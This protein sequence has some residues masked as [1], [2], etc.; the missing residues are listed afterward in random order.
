M[1]AVLY[2]ALS[3]IS[4]INVIVHSIGLYL[5]LC[6]QKN[7]DE[8]VQQI[9]IINLSVVE[10]FGNILWFISD[11]NKFIVFDSI[12]PYPYITQVNDYVSFITCT[13]F[14]FVYYMSMVLITI[15]K[16]LEIFL[17]IKY[18]LYCSA[19]RAKYLVYL[20]WMLGCF[21]C[22]GII[23]ACKIYGLQYQLPFI[24]FVYPA[25]DIFLILIVVI[26]YSYIFH[27]YKATRSHPFQRQDSTLSVF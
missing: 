8:N 22:I 25:F 3:T 20:T 2:G 12:T 21:F 24:K 27:R 18:T 7:Y 11:L 23:L 10:I 17:N 19:L 26:C 1:S 16:S 6:I 5:L 4:F 14:L 15:D 9:Y 13:V